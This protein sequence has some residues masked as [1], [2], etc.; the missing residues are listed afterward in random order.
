MFDVFLTGCLYISWRITFRVIFANYLKLLNIFPSAPENKQTYI[1]KLTNKL[2]QLPNSVWMSHFL[3]CCGLSH[4]SPQINSFKNFSQHF[5]IL[6]KYNLKTKWFIQ[7]SWRFIALSEFIEEKIVFC[8]FLVILVAWQKW[9]GQMPLNSLKIE[10]LWGILEA[11]CE[12]L[13]HFWY[14][15]IFLRTNSKWILRLK[16]MNLVRK[17]KGGKIE[18]LDEELK[19]ND[20][21]SANHLLICHSHFHPVWWNFW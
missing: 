7:N 18:F 1:Q 10:T 21:S 12:T 3:N 15:V 6:T 17:C 9:K 8:H 16:F 5:T 2:I 20:H 11:F 19:K 4:H 14:C 13:N